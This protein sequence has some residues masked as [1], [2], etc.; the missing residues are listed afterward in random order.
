MGADFQHDRE[1]SVGTPRCGVREVIQTSH[2]GTR[3]AQRTVP[4]MDLRLRCRGEVKHGPLIFNEL[5]EHV[6]GSRADRDGDCAK[7]QAKL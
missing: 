4:T 2:R 3:T 5:Q 7:R 1:E 6:I